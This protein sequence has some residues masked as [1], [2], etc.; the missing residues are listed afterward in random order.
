M[1]VYSIKAPNGQTYEIE[2]PDGATQDQVQAEV[3]RQFPEAGTIQGE[4]GGSFNPETGLET[5][6]TDDRPADGAEP[7]T[8]DSALSGFIGGAIKPI[9]NIVRAALQN[10]TFAA[11]D[12]SISDA[13]GLPSGREAVDANDA[14]RADNSR[15]GWQTIGTIG[16][17]L[18]TLALPGGGL[19][20]GAAAGALSTDARDFGGV[21]KDAI[22]GGAIGR[23][24]DAV[25]GLIAPQVSA[26]VRRL[27][28][29]GVRL[30]PGQILGQGGALGRLAK[31]AEDII[32]S[33]PIAGAAV[34]AA[35]ERGVQDLNSAAINR[36]LRPIGERLP[37]DLRSGNDAVRFAG[38]KLSA[39]YNEVLPQLSGQLDQTFGRRIDAIR[40]RANLPQEYTQMLDNALGEL[41]NAFTRTSGPNGTFSGRSLRDASERLNDLASAWRK[42]DDPYIRIVGDTTEQFRQ[43]LHALARRQNPQAAKRLRDIDRGYASLVRV[44]KAAAGTPDGAFTPAQYQSATRMTDR[45]ARRRASARGQALDQD[46]SSAANTVMTNRAAQGGSKDI[47]SLIGLGVGAGSALSGNPYAIAGAGLIGAGSAAY[48]RPA[49]A[50]ARGILARNP[51]LTE[52]VIADLV[53][54]GNRAVSPSATTTISSLPD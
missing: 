15:T 53:R 44:E 19:A 25:A 11:I 29:E 23:A 33:V 36:A 50:V 8:D 31:N 51:S 9:D 2:G 26:N 16:G 18:P 52:E 37:R 4:D 20:Q 13:V 21:A 45:S 22:I 27:I 41:E 46:L 48:S 35:Q 34:R 40:S 39:A 10:P 47:N 5:T 7:P 42:S 3:L 12:K 32:G 54:Y 38:D 28:D 14:M 6:V 17:T 1:P 30:T 43:Q 49:Q 24:G